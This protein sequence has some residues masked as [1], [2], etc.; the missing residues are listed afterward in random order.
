MRP[1]RRAYS[2][3][4][5]LLSP[6]TPVPVSVRPYTLHAVAPEANASIPS[7]CPVV[8]PSAP[9]ACTAPLRPPGGRAVANRLALV[10][11]DETLSAGLGPPAAAV[12][13]PARVV[14]SPAAFAAPRMKFTVVAAATGRTF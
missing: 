4:P 6:T 7:N 1:E 10:P 5:V 9:R 12:V 14:G 8:V 2:P 3:M 13:S 11:T